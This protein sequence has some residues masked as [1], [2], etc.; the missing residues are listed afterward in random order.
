MSGWVGR[1]GEVG[2]C[3]VTAQEHKRVY[4]V[5]VSYVFVLRRI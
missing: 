2:G 3:S 1:G 5:P 4:A